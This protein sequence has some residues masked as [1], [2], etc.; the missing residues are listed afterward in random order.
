MTVTVF[1]LELPE[2]AALARCASATPGCVVSALGNGY[3]K[4]E[5]PHEL[6]FVR[7]ELGLGPAL[8]NSALCG[9]FRGRIAAYDRHELRLVSET[10]AP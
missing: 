1:V 10:A 5:A 6:R 4:I 9:G 7:K 8:W 2:F 3:L